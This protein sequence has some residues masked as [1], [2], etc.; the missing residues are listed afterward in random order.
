MDSVPPA[1][2]QS[3][4]PDWIFAVAI[5][6][7]SEPDAQYRLM[8]TPG[9]LSVFKPIKEINLATFKPCSASGI[10]FPTIR[11]SILSLSNSGT[12]AISFSITVA[13]ISSGRV[14]RREPFGALPTAVLYPLMMYAVF[15]LEVRI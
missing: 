3:A 14:N 6:I 9:T 12:S 1:I 5:A 2:M 13:A 4:I 11:S 10:A 7:A 8:V 15:I